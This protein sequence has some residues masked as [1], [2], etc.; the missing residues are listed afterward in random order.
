[1]VGD[2]WQNSPRRSK[3]RQ[4]WDEFQVFGEVFWGKGAKY[5]GFATSISVALLQIVLKSTPNP[6]LPTTFQL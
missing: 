2:T 3:T 6:E 1:M 5:G 4:V